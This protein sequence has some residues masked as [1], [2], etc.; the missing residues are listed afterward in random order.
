MK[1][2]AFG[3]YINYPLKYKYIKAYLKVYSDVYLTGLFFAFES[4]DMHLIFCL[5]LIPY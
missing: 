3:Q 2:Q 5:F 1:N 4:N